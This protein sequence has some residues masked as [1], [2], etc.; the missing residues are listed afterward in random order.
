VDY[1][2][3]AAEM[4]LDDVNRW[5]SLAGKAAALFC[6]IFFLSVFDGLISLFEQSPNDLRLLPGTSVKINGPAKES[7]RDITELEYVATTDHIQVSFEAVHAGYWMGGRMWRGVLTSSPNTAPGEYGVTID[8][9]GQ[10]SEKPMTVFRI[11]VFGDSASLQKNSDSIIQRYTGCSP[12]WVVVPCFI[13]ALLLFGIVYL[14]SQKREESLRQEGKAEIYRISKTDAG[15]E[16]SF[17]LGTK[18]GVQN[19]SRL[20]LLDAEGIPIG[21]VKVEVAY[22]ADSTALAPPEI[23]VKPGY[24]VSIDLL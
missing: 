11:R 5:R 22:E 1:Y 12:W 8:I 2:Q 6:I 13:L 9:K 23:M 7:I 3:E 15:Y 21:I 10:P 16:I 20:K 17:G 19:G 4:T 14:C 24:M 18:H